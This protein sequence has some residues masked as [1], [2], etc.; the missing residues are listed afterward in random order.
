[1][2]NYICTCI[3]VTKPNLVGLG[4][5][6]HIKYLLNKGMVN[7]HCYKLHV[8]V[9]VHVHALILL[10]QLLILLSYMYNVQMYMFMDE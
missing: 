8:P 4:L 7:A 9:H 3:H 6:L 10:S 1:M 5:Q 2:D